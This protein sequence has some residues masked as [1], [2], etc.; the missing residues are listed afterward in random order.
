MTNMLQLSENLYPT[1]EVIG[2]FL[3]CIVCREDVH[4][5]LFWLW[6]LLYSIP[7]VDDGLV[8]IYKMFY[9]TNNSNIGRYMSRKIIEY[10][11]T[12]NKRLLADIVINLRN[13]E[14]NYLSYMVNYYGTVY[15]HPTVIY[16]TKKW[17][18]PY[19]K[20]MNNVFGALKIADY[21]NLGYYL[22]QSL[23]INGY[24]KTCLALKDFGLSNGIDITDGIDIELQ[25]NDMLDISSIVSRLISAGDR[26]PKGHFLRSDKTLVQNIDNHFTKKSNKYYLKLTERRLY[27]THS[28]LPPG[29]YSRFSVSDLKTSCWYNWEYYAYS[30]LEWSKRFSTYKG[31]LDHEKKTIKWLDDDHLEAFYDDDN[32]MD[33]DEQSYETQMKSLHSICVCQTAE[34]WVSKL[35]DSRF[36]KSLGE[37]KI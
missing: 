20:N 22:A 34:E 4:E 15:Q 25:S 12:D 19:P 31:E 30:S 3:Q 2:T 33:F 24:D 7:N 21:K 13:L 28:L 26:S 17:M 9:S 14:P 32:A 23:N 18:E 8:C 37:I 36:A 27:P 35:Q 6:E 10:K 1:D 29:D 11:K 16:K 5:T